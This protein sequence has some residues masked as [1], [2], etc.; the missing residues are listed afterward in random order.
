MDWTAVS[1]AVSPILALI[2]Y[3]HMRLSTVEKG[4]RMSVSESEVKEILNYRLEN[5][6]AW[7]ALCEKR[8]DRIE[9][10]LDRLA[11]KID[12]LISR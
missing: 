5:V 2:G 4:I 8:L 6:Q 7:Q 3:V 9:E 12:Q 11:S 10:S 1:I